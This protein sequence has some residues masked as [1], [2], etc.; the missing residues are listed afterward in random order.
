VHKAITEKNNWNL[1]DAKWTLEVY[2]VGT[3]V[4]HY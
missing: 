3:A 4:E 1:N 2:A